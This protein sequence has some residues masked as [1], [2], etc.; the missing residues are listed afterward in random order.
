MIGAVV[1]NDLVENLIVLD[2]A[3][4]EEMAAALGAEIVDARPYGL[5]IGDLRT[6]S[7]WTRN[8]GGEQKLLPELEVQK[9]VSYEELVEELETLKAQQDAVADAAAQEALDIL[10]GE[11]EL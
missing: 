5:M 3:Q 10:T 9:Q 6:S 4:V 11:V 2:E 1:R 8:D 7:G